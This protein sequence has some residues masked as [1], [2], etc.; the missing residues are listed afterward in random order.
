[1]RRA[2]LRCDGASLIAD[3]SGALIWPEQSLLVV[4]DLHL[5]KASSLA[6]RGALL[7][8]YDTRSTL[9]R[10]EAALGRWRPR[11][12]ISLGDGFHDREASA[13]LA[14]DDRALLERLIAAHDWLWVT[15]N[16]DPAPPRDL[17]GRTEAAIEIGGIVLRHVP[18]GASDRAEIA[19]HLHPSASVTVRGRRLHR[20]CFAGDDRRVL[21][22]AF[23]SYT[24]GLA[25]FDPAIAGL[26]EHGFRAT[27]LGEREVHAVPHHRLNRPGAGRMRD[28]RGFLRAGG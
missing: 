9:C 1:M 7:P 26:F 25:V 8:P 24:G 14:P 10:L 22:P 15:G 4:A 5:E 2:W 28:L 23:G 20:R 3:V 6:R 19:G 27:L 12:V 16:H 18:D 17:G 21:L 11:R 13:R